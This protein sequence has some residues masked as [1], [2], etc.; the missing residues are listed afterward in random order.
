MSAEVPEELQHSPGAP[1]LNEQTQQ[2]LSTMVS[3][4][5][6]GDRIFTKEKLFFKSLLDE[7]S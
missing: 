6:F 1:H 7:F 4:F 5:R 3:G 2:V